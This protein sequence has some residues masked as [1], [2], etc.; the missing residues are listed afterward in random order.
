NVRNEMLQELP[1]GKAL[2]TIVAIRDALDVLDQLT[3][4]VRA[5]ILSDGSGFAVSETDMVAAQV[6]AA[7]FEFRER[8]RAEGRDTCRVEIGAFKRRMIQTGASVW[9]IALRGRDS[10][11][12]VG[13]TH[14]IWNEAKK[15]GDENFML[16][17]KVPEIQRSIVLAARWAHF[18]FPVVQLH[19]HK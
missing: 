2:Q 7:S 13:A 6:R 12:L 8:L 18:A 9:P 11:D 4:D 15:H 3:P 17:M 5:Q 19:G 1:D 16:S 10:D 14:R